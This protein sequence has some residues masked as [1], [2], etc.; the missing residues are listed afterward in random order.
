M[1]ANQLIDEK[2]ADEIK[3]RQ[4]K[5]GEAE[6]AVI[7]E[8]RLASESDGLRYRQTAAYGHFGRDGESFTWEKTDMVKELR[9]YLK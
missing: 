8:L 9:K 5:T 2:Q 1:R 3:L 4:L 6:E 7:R